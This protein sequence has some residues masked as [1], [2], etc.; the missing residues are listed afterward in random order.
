VDDQPPPDEEE[1]RSSLIFKALTEA[2]DHAGL[3]IVVS[4]WDPIDPT[5]L[6]AT[7]MNT[8][9]AQLLGVPLEEIGKRSVLSFLTPEGAV[10]VLAHHQQRLRGE[11]TPR[12]F[13]AEVWHRDGHLIPVEVATTQVVLAGRPANVTFLSDV[14]HRKH[15]EELLRK[16]E[17]RFRT[18]IENAPDG[19]AITRWPTIVYVNEVAAHLLGFRRV[20]DAL[21]ADITKLM[22]PADSERA[23]ARVTRLRQSGP[24]GDRAEYTSRDADGNEVSVEISSIPIEYEG[25]PAILAF[26][27]DVTERKAMVAQLMAADKLAAVG[28]LAAGV[29]HEINNPLAY[30]LL[31]LE[32]IIR[33][34]PKL[35]GDASLLA[36]MQ[37]RLHETKEGAERVKTIVRDLQTFTRRDEGIRGPVDLV[38][39]IE[40]ALHMARHQI[41]H[42]ATVIKTFDEVPAVYGNTTRFEQLFLNLLINAAHAVA[43]LE[44][45]ESTIEISLRPGSGGTVIA[46][47]RDNGAGMPPDVLKR[48]FDPFFTTKPNGVGTG[49]GLPICHGIVGAVGGEIRIESQLGEGTVVTVVLP[50]HSGTPPASRSI[51]PLPFMLERGRRG[52]VL[53]IDDE[54]AVAEALAMALS[55]H[56]EVLVAFSAAEARGLFA[57]GETFDVVLCDLVMPQ[58]TGMQLFE[59]VRVAHP[60]QARRFAFMSGGA[61]LPEAERFLQQVENPSIEK[62]FDVNGVRSLVRAMI[63]GV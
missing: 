35:V 12:V 23:D 41:R 28:T 10:R 32:F 58:E 2:A 22:S 25:S 39:A 38:A 9:T 48:V 34:L 57:S 59:H 44:T 16:S 56:H 29:A 49:L 26:A 31:N 3:S 50:A 63:E 52:R 47:V 33:E 51:S 1:L 14:S 8:A 19:V 46:S 18:V 62:P 15:A 17:A 55:D 4:Y 13:E 20:E 21:G 40:A 5:R 37:Q 53:L 24:L 45:Q 54:R 27:R 43:E 11:K 61:F 30:L 6:A 60:E 7:Y 36:P 42:R